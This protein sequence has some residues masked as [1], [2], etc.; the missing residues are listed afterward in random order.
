MD[1]ALTDEQ[2]LLRDTAQSL[3]AKEC[4]PSLLRAHMDDPSAVDPLWKHL[5]EWT[6]LGAG[7]LVDLCLFLEETGAVLAPGPFFATTALFAPLAGMAGVDAEDTVGTVAL[8]GRGGEWTPNDDR[9]K[10]YVPE[11]D[12]VDAVAVVTG[13]EKPSLVLVEDPDVRPVPTIDTT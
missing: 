13:R 4:P 1:F 12:R 6:A 3:L 7:P 10:A 2:Q 9:T 5:R 11:A 8:A